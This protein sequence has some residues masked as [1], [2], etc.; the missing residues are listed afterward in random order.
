MRW[1]PSYN[2]EHSGSLYM[3]L[4][5]ICIFFTIS[6]GPPFLV[7]ARYVSF[8]VALD[9]MLSQSLNYICI[10][11]GNGGIPIASTSARR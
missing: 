1:W 9:F 5:P 6:F 4:I 7:Q 11:D 3:I 2:Y 8:P 10:G